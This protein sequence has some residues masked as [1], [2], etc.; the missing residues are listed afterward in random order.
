MNAYHCELKVLEALDYLILQWGFTLSSNRRTADS[1]PCC[2][3]CLLFPLVVS[4]LG[5]V[6]SRESQWGASVIQ[7]HSSVTPEHQVL[8]LLSLEAGKSSAFL[9]RRFFHSCLST[10]SCSQLKSLLGVQLTSLPTSMWSLFLYLNS[11]HRSYCV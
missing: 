9:F 5:S 6:A 1:G 11:P 7:S 8:S 3:C 10:L 4:A 2:V